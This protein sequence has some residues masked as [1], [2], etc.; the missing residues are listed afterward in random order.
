MPG[1]EEVD[2]PIIG[3]VRIPSKNASTWLPLLRELYRFEAGRISGPGS[4]RRGLDETIWTREMVFESIP[5][6]ASAPEQ[7]DALIEFLLEGRQAME[8]PATGGY[9]TRYITRTGELV[10]TLGH[11][12]EFWHRGRPGVT[13]TRWLVED[14]K[15]PERTIPAEDFRNEVLSKLE[16]WV[17]GGPGMNL[18]K[19]AWEVCTAVAET[20]AQQIG[21]DWADVSF[22]RF[23]MDSTLRILEARYRGTSTNKAQVLTAGVGSG[24]TIGFSIAALI[25][26]RKSMIDGNSGNVN[27]RTISLFVYPRTQ[28]CRDQHREICKFATNMKDKDTQDDVGLEPW[29]ELSETYENDGDLKYVTR[30]VVKKYG[31]ETLP[32][33]VIVTTYE[34]LKRRM[35]RPEFMAKISNHLSTVVLDEIH[36]TS[37]VSGGMASYLLSRLSA[38]A[39]GE[40]RKIY[41]IGASATIARPDE[42]AARLF[43]IEPGEVGVVDPKPEELVQDGINHHVF[44][45]PNSGMSTLGVLVNTTS[46]VLHQRRDN[47]PTERGGELNADGVYE[48]ASNNG[49]TDENRSKAIG[50]ADN[51]EMLGRWNDDFRENERTAEEW[52][53]YGRRHAESEDTSNWNPKQRELPYI[54]RFHKPLQRRLCSK[55]GDDTHRSGNPGDALADLSNLFDPEIAATV[56]DRCMSGERVELGEIS[57]EQLKELSKLVH[58]HPHKED[59]PFKAFRLVSEEFK[60]NSDSEPILIG[61]HEMCPMLRSG[62][63]SWFPQP[64]PEGVWKINAKSQRDTPRYEF[65][66]SALSTV[67][68]AKSDKETEG[69]DSLASFIFQEEER[70]VFDYGRFGEKVPV[71][72]VLASPS[73]EVGVDLPK[74]TE[75]VMHKAVRNIA[76]YRQKAGRVGRESN[77]EVFN[78]S[79]MSDTSV[80]LHYYRQPRKLVSEGR[81]EPVPLMDENRAIKAC[82]AYGAVWEWLALNSPL[83]EWIK[84]ADDGAIGDS[85]RVCRDE[86]DARREDVVSHIHLATKG[87]LQTGDAG[88]RIVSD[89]INQ[90]LKEID[91]LLLPAG[92]TYALNPIPTFEFTV[93]DLFSMERK[94]SSQYGS[95]RP[96]IRKRLDGINDADI[97]DFDD[98]C[99]MINQEIR[100]LRPE[101]LLDEHPQLYDEITNLQYLLSSKALT[102]DEAENKFRTI[103]E[104]GDS[105]QDFEMDSAGLL[106]YLSRIRGILSRMES[107]G[108]D[109]RVESMVE[110]YKRLSPIAQSYLSESI[111][112]LGLIKHTR[113]DSWFVR[114]STLFENPYSPEVDLLVQE[115]NPE[116]QPTPLADNQSKVK[117]H[118]ALF[119]F[120]PGTWT[121][122]IPH[123]RLK[124]R[125]GELTSENGRLVATL[126]QM[127]DPSVG[128]EF[129]P[130]HLES[131]PSPP[132]SLEKVRVWAPT[133]LTLISISDKYVTLDKGTEKIIDNDEQQPGARAA[134]AVEEDIPDWESKQVKIPRTFSN[135]WTYSEPGEG[136]E[137][138]VFK[139]RGHTY[140]EEVGPDSMEEIIDPTEIKHPLRDA[141]LDSIEWHEE[142]KVTEYTYSNSRSYS[143]AG[144][145]ELIYRDEHGRTV[146]FGE[147]FTTEGFSIELNSESVKRIC[148]NLEEAMLNGEGVS[149]PSL[150]KAFKAH[151]SC[152]TEFG[153]AGINPY[154]L[155]DLISV[156]LMHNKW[157]GEPISVD[158]WSEM[159]GNS[160]SSDNVGIFKEIAEDYYKRKMRLM[161][162]LSDDEDEGDEDGDNLAATRAGVL[163]E[164]LEVVNSGIG[165]FKDGLGLWVH[166]TVLSTF[167]SV[168]TTALQKFS[169][170]DEKDMSYLIAPD[171]WEGDCTRVTVYDRAQ[172]GNGSCATAREYMHIPHVLRYSKNA[173]RSKLPTTDFLSILE[174]GLLQCMQHQS[175][176]GALSIHTG[177]GSIDH[178]PDLKKHCMETCDVGRDTWGR[179]GVSGPQDAWTL[180]LHKR[181]A[182]H[183][184]ATLSEDE[185]M[186]ADDVVRACTSCWNGCPECVDEI[187]NTLGGFRGLDFIDKYVLDSWFT[188]TVSLAEDYGIYGFNEISRGSADMHL[189]SLNKLHLVTPDGSKIRS[190]CLPWTMGFLTSRGENLEPR[191]IMRHTDVSKMRIGDPTGTAEGIES[192]GFRRLLWFNLLMTGHLDSVGAIRG[193]YWKCRDCEEEFSEQEHQCSKCGGDLAIVNDK[194][195]KFLYFDIRN[196]SFQ[197][198]GLSPRML[199]SMAA[200]SEG[201]VLEKLSDVLHWMLKRGF[202]IE[203]CIDRMRASE[204]RVM[205]FLT[206]LGEWDN[207]SV[208]AMPPD[209]GGNMHKKILISPIAA[210]SGSAN[211]TH[212][213]T[214]FSQESISHTMRYNDTQYKS[215]QASSRTTFSQAHIIDPSDMRPPDISRTTPS[216]GSPEPLSRVDSLIR[217]MEQGNF[218]GEGWD[219][220]FKP[221]YSSGS[222][223]HNLTSKDT[224]DISLIEVASMLNTDGGLMVVGVGDPANTESGEW[225]VHGIDREIEPMGL[226]IYGQHVSDSLCQRFGT[227]ISSNN[228]R[229]H[230]KDVSGNKV[231]I[232]E[233]EPSLAA[234]ALL[235]PG[236]GKWKQKL[237]QMAETSGQGIWVRVN[238]SARHLIG[239]SLLE[240][241]RER[242]A[243]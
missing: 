83:P 147:D 47:L 188:D 227:G 183:Y 157:K 113:K 187:R 99:N 151:V 31:D 37:G 134:A 17:P 174:E 64:D 87:R 153:G 98:S 220:E 131:L 179:I 95:G 144:D 34:T 136:E 11:T 204:A 234:A 200:V 218:E 19:A 177:G 82:S 88:Q 8:F 93:I 43:G 74:L 15:I 242:F 72:I 239:P 80:D 178:L 145:I 1:E 152:D 108:F 219:I 180:P 50:F 4:E 138:G 226:D 16:E 41:W 190:I 133:K 184:E 106:L 241:Y 171:S 165:G 206:T 52:K 66:S 142:L 26:A 54:L 76:S 69:E 216:G 32:M 127:M 36:L 23:Q 3:H 146:A 78:L 236:G 9:P 28:L 230:I 164:A 96:S 40:G 209:F 225:E 238:D 207:L 61:S 132:G 143:A 60:P 228:I 109:Q 155:E 191:L 140:T 20:I 210:M 159:I 168:A 243:N 217:D 123:R 86:L 223:R 102:S 97:D 197:D 91:L 27:H 120:Q 30:G 13:A 33:P 169:G 231:L 115:L 75:S 137:I 114:P 122:R 48:M 129:R 14:K 160:S 215:L 163:I 2:V 46:K 29:L 189:G 62:A 117:L 44:I 229:Y 141:L 121:H 70:R 201:A 161:R 92:S 135:R 111:E 130:I 89:A 63:C 105:V 149:T 22:S 118:E 128:N 235:K 77:L 119:G 7:F 103:K 182:V 167:G 158:L 67:F 150:I 124:V 170:S 224:I 65:A 194:K 154:A 5:T 45:R 110:D 94:S 172:F 221:S 73:L 192:H 116:R 195:I 85:L 58:R 81:L 10:R 101:R 42:H 213:G 53:R 232:F 203:L 156:L 240:W 56:C 25:E 90:V 148:S 55:G 51:L 166:R 193:E 49:I 186:F 125:T 208:R 104:L 35:R 198:V 202:D 237:H 126:E 59:D 57:S 79:L 222:K 181:L 185:P 205:D 71:D 175:D 38:A 21:A 84:M 68:S 199:D 162:T 39:R 214:E 139:L 24:K 12:Y 211:L 107:A 176:M 100:R 112:G 233:I 18:K 196:I 6:A 212:Y 173:D